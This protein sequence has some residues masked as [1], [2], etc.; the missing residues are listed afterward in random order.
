MA[1]LE[2]VRAISDKYPKIPP[3]V[4]THKGFA[5]PGFDQ[6]GAAPRDVGP[7]AKANP[8]VRFIDLP[9]GLRHLQRHGVPSAAS[10]RPYAGDDKVDSSNRTVDSL[11][12]EPARERLDA[13]NFAEQGKKFGNVPNV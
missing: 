9:L 4:A 13:A 2:Q 7:A 3:V 1:F 12:Q 10:R 5:L 11:H 8:G 6:R